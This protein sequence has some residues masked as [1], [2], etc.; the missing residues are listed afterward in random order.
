MD[1]ALIF[2]STMHYELIL[3]SIKIKVLFLEFGYLFWNH[4]FGKFSSLF[5]NYIASG[6]YTGLFLA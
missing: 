5:L 4:L 2:K 1:L 6:L 3:C